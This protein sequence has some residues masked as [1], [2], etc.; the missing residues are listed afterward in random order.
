MVGCYHPAL[1]PLSTPV[2]KKA[3]THFARCRLQASDNWFWRMERCVRNTLPPAPLRNHRG[4]LGCFG[5]ETVIHG[6]RLHLPRIGC[7]SK[8]EQRPAVG[9]ARYGN[10]EPFDSRRTSTQPFRDRESCRERVCQ[11]VESSVV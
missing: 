8:R 5:A 4:F 10:T 2:P 3:I 11:Y 6:R 7:V 9:S 1:P